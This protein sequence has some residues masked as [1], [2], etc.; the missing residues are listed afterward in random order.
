[1]VS[2]AVDVDAI[3][4]E[5]PAV[6]ALREA[7]MKLVVPLFAQG[8]LIGMLNLG[9]RLSEREYSRDDRKLLADLAGYAAP[10][11]RVAQLV[12]EQEAEI[13]N[14]ERL[15]QELR[16]AT[17]IQQQFLPKELPDL[18]GWRISAYYQPAREVGGDF[19][20][21]IE[22]PEGQVGIVVGDVTD[23][24]VPA[25]LVMATTHS[26][27][28]SDAPRIVAPGEV[29]ARANELLVA[30]MPPAMFVTC[31]YAVLDPK[32]GRLRY[33]NA[34]HDLPYVRTRHGVMELRATGMPLGLMP[35]MDYE[36]KEIVLEPGAGLLLHSDG[37]VEAHNAER[38]MF[39]FP[40][41]KKLVGERDGG[42]ELIDLLLEELN[43]F[44]VDDW[45]QED[46]IT[47]VTLQRAG[48]GPGDGELLADFSLPSEQ[49]NEKLAIAEIAKAVAPLGLPTAQI[50]RLKTA[51]AEA[52][53]NAI[54]HGNHN[55][56]ELP[57]AIKLLASPDRLTVR[58][59][60]QG[61]GDELVP[62]PVTPDLDA[63][64]AGQQS[65]RGWGL[66]LIEHMVDELRTTDDGTQHTIE[67]VVKREATAH[68]SDAV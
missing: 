50:E 53:M 35:G 57:V 68:G 9:P 25:A 63:K 34:G 20:D 17:A 48:G 41:L 39:G 36:E 51:V 5:S 11:V 13:R 49:G 66:F 42:E 55:R 4:I 32:T 38:K 18:P 67:L 14:R 27:L 62:T 31:L 33:A 29:L 7:G 8:E 37:L 60:D 10:A 30:E 65:P 47:L 26:I 54:E 6:T 52:T 15:A 56:A 64:L 2:G 28:R 46:D 24:G 43:R 61:G 45:E 58:I 12:R 1:M 40:R 3:E 23:K 44:T 16:V 59:T 19:Y 22:L 21:F